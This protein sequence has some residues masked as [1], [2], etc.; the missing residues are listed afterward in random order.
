VV[1]WEALVMVRKLA[2]TLA[3]SILKDPYLQILA[4][5]LILV[6]SALATAYVQPYESASLN[7]L[8]TLGLFAL[9]VTQI[10]SILYFYVA[11]SPNQLLD[12]EAIEATVTVLLFAVNISA[13]LGFFVYYCM[14]MTSL[15]MRLE[16]KRCDVFKVCDEEVAQAVLAE[17]VL[18][19]EGHQMWCHPTGIA[20]TTFPTRLERGVW[21]WEGVNPEDD[22][23]A[24]TVEPELL[25]RVES[26]GE[27]HAGNPFRLVNKA[28]LAV[29]AKQIR[30]VDVGA[31]Q[32]TR[33]RGGQRCCAVL[34]M[35][36]LLLFAA[37]SSKTG[38]FGAIWAEKKCE[39]GSWR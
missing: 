12:P 13:M 8:D 1:A 15:H 9:I 7:L 38:V 11:A 29:S 31:G 25:L 17:G 20:V 4:A 32:Q 18:G 33:Q 5:L 35:W 28:T 14:E 6:V 34:M 24:S 37:F 16:K 30:P 27:L 3:G 19:I 2:V 36:P 22:V 26:N 39:I 10:F 21:L 23:C